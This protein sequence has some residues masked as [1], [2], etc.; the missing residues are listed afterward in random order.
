MTLWSVE[1]ITLT[2]LRPSECLGPVS[3]TSGVA[4]PGLATTVDIGITL[5]VPSWCA[6]SAHCFAGGSSRV[7]VGHLGRPRAILASGRHK[8]LAPRFPRRSEE[9]TSELQSR[10]HLVCR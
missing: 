10:G 7:R 2:I 5:P 3:T 9:H 1:V 4:V 6:R 8:H